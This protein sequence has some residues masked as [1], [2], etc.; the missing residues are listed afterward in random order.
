MSEHAGNYVKAISPGILFMAMFDLQRR[1]LIQMGHSSYQ[2]YVVIVSTFL[3]IGWNYLFIIKLKL[4]VVG[5]GF[6]ATLS[7]LF[8][9]IGNIIMTHCC[10]DLK[11]ALQVTI[12]NKDVF[13]NLCEYL[14]LGV[15]GIFI[16]MSTWGSYEILNILSGFLGVKNQACQVILNNIKILL[17]NLPMGIQMAACGIIG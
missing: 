16:M 11:E 8:L 9:L 3:H 4:G 15:P 13:N 2:L 17:Y 1:F 5:I 10:S 14:T 6:T 12:C 7:N